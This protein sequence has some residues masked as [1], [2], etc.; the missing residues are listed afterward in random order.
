MNLIRFKK[1][2]CK[3]LHLG[4]GYPRCVY[5]LGE[6]HLEGRPAEKDLG[7]LVDVKT[8]HEPAV[9]ACSLKG[10]WYPGF[11]QKRGGQQGKGGDCPPLLCPCE[12]SAGGALT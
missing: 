2:K 3:V 4:Q 12:A 5:K 8:E 7:I 9:C 11:C 1:A 10:Q 6:E